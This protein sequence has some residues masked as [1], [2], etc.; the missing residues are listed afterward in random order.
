MPDVIVFFFPLTTKTVNP[1]VSVLTYPI[2]NSSR[3]LSEAFDPIL[4][5]IHRSAISQIH[6]ICFSLVFTVV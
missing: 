5:A 1:R 6:F 3:F 2:Q 4:H